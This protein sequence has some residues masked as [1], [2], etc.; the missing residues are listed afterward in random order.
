MDNT[1]KKI[2]QIKL[3]PN[4]NKIKSNLFKEIVIIRILYLIFD[5]YYFP[6]FKS[7]LFSD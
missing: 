3:F 6:M 5:K 1:I 4:F 7:D 2:E